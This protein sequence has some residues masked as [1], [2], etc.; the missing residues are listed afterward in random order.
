LAL[1]KTH[2]ASGIAVQNWTLGSRIA[3]YARPSPVFILDQR[4]DQFDLWFGNLKPGADAIAV[5]WSA[6]PYA[7]PVKGDEPHLQGA[8]TECHALERVE[9]R[10]LGR[11]LSHFDLSLCKNWTAKDPN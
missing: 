5:N 2:A 11:V 1:S 4:Q 6:M 3:W 10:H 7:L 9:V 8:F